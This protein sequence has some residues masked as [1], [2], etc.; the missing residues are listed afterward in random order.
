[1]GRKILFITTDQQRY[2]SLGCNGG[3]IARTPV[4]DG[5]AADG[6]NY[7][8]AYNQNTVCMPAR[9]TM[10]TGQYVRT[11]GVVANGVPLPDDAPS[12]SPQYLA[13]RRP[14]T[15]PRCSARRTS[16]PAST[17]TLKW[18]ENYMADRGLDRPVPRLR[19]RRAG[20]A[21]RRRS[22]S[23]RSSTTAAGSIDTHGLEATQGLLAAARGRARRRHRRARD[24][25]Q[26]DPARV[27]PHRLGRRPHDRV[28]R[29]AARRRRLVRVDV[30]PRPAPPVGSARVGA[31]PRA[32]GSDL[33]LPPGHPGSHEEIRA[34][35]RAEAG[36]LARVLGRHVAST[37]RAG[38][39]RYRARRT[40]AHD[41][42]REI[43]AMTHIMNEL[44][45]EACGRVLDTVDRAAGLGRRHRRVLHH[46]PRRAAGR[47][48][49][50]LQGPVP[51][52]LA[53]AAADGVAAGAVGR[54]R[55]GGRVSEPVGQLDLAPTFCAIAGVDPAGVDAGRAAADG[56]PAPGA[57]ARC[58]SG[59]GSSPA[60]ACT[61]ARSTA[62]AGCA[63][64][65]S[66]STVGEPNGLE[67]CP[68]GD[69][70]VRRRHRAASA[71]SRTTAPKASCTTSTTTRT[72]ARTAGTTPAYKVA[73]R[74]PRRRPLRQPAG[75]A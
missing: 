45:D 56:A 34:R 42:I 20:G 30:V 29:L 43:N 38:P 57:S 9:S 2:D 28:P 62:T 48:R 35:A 59:T 52:R 64:R 21:R 36:A 60:T 18:P 40:S 67:E 3:T 25:D 16:S 46:R 44:I 32:T 5:L 23:A 70:H 12:R 54:R 33:D 37:P 68:R 61:C 14:A 24:A 39:A 47:L 19:A 26:P 27:V 15:A 4:V 13:R 6:I 66:Q 51:H 22:A 1:M 63:R 8:R 49:A 31:A 50:R 55:A 65:T 53:D 11:H 71:R 41:N 10:L 75:R 73:A 74:R 7:D 69:R 72:S 17:P 58:A